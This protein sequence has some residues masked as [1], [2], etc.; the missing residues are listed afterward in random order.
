MRNKAEYIIQQNEYEARRDHTGGSP[1][2]VHETRSTDTQT[3]LSIYQTPVLRPP[4]TN[5]RPIRL[6]GVAFHD[7]AQRSKQSRERGSIQCGDFQLR[8]RRACSCDRTN[9]G[10][11]RLKTEEREF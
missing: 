11:A 8:S 6:T 5:T 2:V 9:S 3:S 4:S 7:F 10:R 1:P